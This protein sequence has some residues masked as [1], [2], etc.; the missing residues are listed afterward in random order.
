MKNVLHMKK[1]TQK[2]QKK[3]KKHCQ[4]GHF[5]LFPYRQ[6]FLLSP[7]PKQKLLAILITTGKAANLSEEWVLKQDVDTIKSLDKDCTTILESESDYKKT[8]IEIIAKRPI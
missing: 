7:L 4:G 3:V 1:W 8:L 5:F 2:F 6:Q